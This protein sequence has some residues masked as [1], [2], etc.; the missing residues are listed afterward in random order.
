MFIRWFA[1]LFLLTAGC[2]KNFH[3]G[4][5]YTTNKDLNYSIELWPDST[6][7]YIK[8]YEWPVDVSLGRWHIDGNTLILNSVSDP[9]T[10]PVRGLS[11]GSYIIFRGKSFSIK[12]DRLIEVDSPKLKYKLYKISN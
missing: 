10:T 8:R 12:H 7:R 4:E 11:A 1:I 2:Q 9:D 5:Y 6:F 3:I